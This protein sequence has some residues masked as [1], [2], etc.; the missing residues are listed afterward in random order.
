MVQ[1][2]PSDQKIQEFYDIVSPLYRDLWAS[3]IHHGYFP[4][5][6][7][8]KEE[9]TEEL[10]KVLAE[11]SSLRPGSKVLD[12]GSGIG[13]TSI[14]LS[15][16]F[17][18]DV[19]GITISPK[20]CEMAEDTASGLDRKPK[21]LIMDA[22]HLTLTGTFDALWAVEVLSHLRDHLN[23]FRTSRQLL[24][25]GGRVCI[26]AW[27]K[28]EKLTAQEEME[29]I[30]PIEEGMYCTLSTPQ[31]Y[32]GLLDETR[33]KV[34]H[35]EDISPKVKKTWE[36]GLNIIKD[37]SVWGFAARHGREFLR[38]LRAFRSMK[39]GYEEEKFLYGIIV[40]ERP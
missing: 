20:Q 16:H 18:C 28:A 11:V 29:F 9:A 25:T 13:G 4:T 31:K 33:F 10:I 24:R 36:I 8:S 27:M 32:L 22:N 2:Q 7:E 23:F 40:A 26:A 34:V 12:I 38:H 37:K 19:T 17:H 14:W 35:F 5:G 1:N 3:H 21:F 39:R 30:R 6:S 15:R